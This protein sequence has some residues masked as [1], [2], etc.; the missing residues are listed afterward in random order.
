[1]QDIDTIELGRKLLPVKA[2]VF[3]EIFPFSI[4]F[5]QQLTIANLGKTLMT[6]MPTALNKRMPQ[7]FDLT[8]PLIECSWNSVSKDNIRLADTSESPMRSA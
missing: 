8:R 7:V 5:D 1:M 3:L 6:V 2:H 4:V